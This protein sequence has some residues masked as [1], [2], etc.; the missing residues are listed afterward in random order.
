MDQRMENVSKS[1]KEKIAIEAASLFNQT[2]TIPL[3]EEWKAV[4]EFMEFLGLDYPEDAQ[5]IARAAG[6]DETCAYVRAVYPDGVEWGWCE[7]CDAF[8]PA[9]M[10]DIRSHA[11]AICDTRLKACEDCGFDLLSDDLSCDRCGKQNS[12]D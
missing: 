8:G 2:C 1:L 4:R 9:I 11:C 6:P 3:A 5:A 10:A 12:V 7:S